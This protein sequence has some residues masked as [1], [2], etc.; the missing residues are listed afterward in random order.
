MGGSNRFQ[1]IRI[2]LV[3][4][5]KCATCGY[6]GGDDRQF[7]DFGFDL[8]FYGAVYFCTGCFTD[9]CMQMGFVGPDKFKDLS[10]IVDEQGSKIQAIVAENA[11]L[12]D[13]LNNLNFLGT[14]ADSSDSP[15]KEPSESA[16]KSEPADN[17]SAKSSNVKRSGSISSDDGD[18]PNSGTGFK[19]SIS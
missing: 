14:V 7:I 17:G 10:Q 15:I 2:P 6:T 4:P 5:G 13:A 11:K 19:L 1:I 12:R 9:A 3:S 18:E 16:Q 8:D